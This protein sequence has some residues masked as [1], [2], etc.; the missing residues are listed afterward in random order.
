MDSISVKDARQ[1]FAQLIRRAQR[2]RTVA[3]LRRGKAVAQIAP[4]PSAKGGGL[5]DLSAFRQSLGA[6]ARK[7]KATVRHLR[8]QERC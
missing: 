2:G 1:Q 4:V 3:I 8:D 7:P 5:P 6:P